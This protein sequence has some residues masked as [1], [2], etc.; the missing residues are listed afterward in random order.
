[1]RVCLFTPIF[2][3]SVGGTEFVTDALARQFQ[4]AGVQT[5]VLA[6]GAPAELDVPYDVR[7]SPKP[8]LIRWRPERSARAL[9]KLHAEKP[10]DLF[11]ANYANPTGYGALR[12]GQRVGVPVVI[13]SHGGDLYRSSKDRKRP[14]L[15]RRTCY[16][17]R[18]ADGLVAISPYVEQLIR[19]IAPSPPPLRSIPNGIDLAT[20]AQPAEPPDDI[21]IDRPFCL[22]LGNLG[23]MKGFDDALTAFAKVRDRLGDMM[24]VVVGSGPLDQALRDQA[25][26]LKLDD[27]VLFAGRR[28]DEAKRWFIQQCRFGLMP[29]IE[30]GHPIVGLEYL[31]SGKPLICTHN[32]AFDGMYE[33]GVNSL[34]IDHQAPDQL[35]DAM[36]QIQTM[37]LGA[38]GR[39]SLRLAQN[40]DWPMIAGRYLEFFE[41]VIAAHAS[42][43]DT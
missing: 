23:P 6:Q 7:W 2:L 13:V 20:Y 10:F 39:E 22:C 32:A 36:L 30:E 3:P 17:Y 29:S 33:H 26:Q 28:V 15:W 4:A 12:L 31:A 38:M 8:R 37:D 16:T 41:E 35:A 24:M 1:M 21:H 34:R 40:Y 42:Q 11:C 5:T 9:A 19:E 27:H 14:G 18:H 43:R 25:K